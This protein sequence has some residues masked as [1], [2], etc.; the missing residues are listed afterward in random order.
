MAG[1]WLQN[2]LIVTNAF[3]IASVHFYGASLAFAPGFW[4]ARLLLGRGGRVVRLVGGTLIIALAVH[5]ATAA[6]FALQ[7]RV[8]YSHW[9]SDFPSLVWFFQFSF[10]SVGA[11]YLFTTAG[12]H[13]YW[14]LAV[15]AFLGFGLWFAFKGAASSH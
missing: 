11:V 2:G 9:H 10:T 5:L 1:V 13:F 15:I 6:I 7:Y 8:F 14:P 3:A 4:L 12:M